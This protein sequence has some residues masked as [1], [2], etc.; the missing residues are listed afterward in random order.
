MAHDT[1]TVLDFGGQYTHL[2]ANTVRKCGVFSNVVDGESRVEDVL[3]ENP[4]G[5]ILSGG[6]ESVY[7]PGAPT[8]DDRLLDVAVKRNIPVLGICY[9]MHLLA[10]LSGGKM[11]H[12]SDSIREYG[13]NHVY[14]NSSHALFNR[15][16][17]EFDLK[18]IEDN[19]LLT[20]VGNLDHRIIGWMSHGDSVVRAPGFEVI[21][22]T[23]D[24]L[25]AMSDPVRNLYGVQFHPEVRHTPEGLQIIG[26][27]V[28]N[29][30]GCGHDW[31][32]GS[33]LEESRQYIRKTVGNND[34][35]CLVS[36]GVDSSLVAALLSQTEGIGKVYCVYINSMMRK[37]ETEEVKRNLSNAGVELMVIDAEDRF[38]RSLQGISDP[39]AKRK[40]I[41][42]LYGKIQQEVCESL[43]LDPDKT[44]LA[45][46]TLYTDLIESGRG[47]GRKAAVIK[48]HHNVGC[49]FIDDLRRIGRIVE[50]NSLIYKDEVR[51]AAKE[52]G[53]PIEIFK[54]QPFPGPGGAI[55]IIDGDPEGTSKVF[56]I[57]KRQYHKDCSE[58]AR[59]AGDYGLD[60]YVLP[61]RTVGVQGDE[62]TYGRLALLRGPR[63]WKNIRAAT[64]RI[65]MEV[66]GVNRVVY[67]IGQGPIEGGYLNQLIPT[68]VN[69]E[70]F[71]QWQDIDHTAMEIMNKYGLNR[72]IAQSIFVLFG[73]D[74]YQINRRSV[75]ARLVLT[76]N[77][78]TVTI[79]EPL[80]LR[81]E[82]IADYRKENGPV[83]LTW[84]V[85]DEIKDALRRDHRIG[86]FVYDVTDKPPATTCW[87]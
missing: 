49:P 74:P 11:D 81:G 85:L 21:G 45:Q 41:G 33:Y 47:I 18:L 83:R 10:Y 52:I 4:K 73:A 79:P 58:V 14:I 1:I 69:P 60:G 13:R 46:G 59:I 67:D 2:I 9:G 84:D 32:M 40:I 16:G 76:P 15:V 87:E 82:Q 38:I 44:F 6:P 50:P 51:V 77:F 68:T 70:T 39:E 64:S 72:E 23:E 35:L 5:L 65:P 57:F 34:V 53:L 30:C 22:V 29:I 75:A 63:D 48:S 71:R 55:R 78:M 17:V 31:T 54:R 62:R 25:A 12:G 61:I 24:H 3:I 27:F 28:H 80:D 56:G 37:N 43:G 86:A 19:R 8:L 66:H 7:A 26:N 20:K 36:G 42:N